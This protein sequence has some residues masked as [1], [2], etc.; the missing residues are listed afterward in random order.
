MVDSAAVVREKCSKRLAQNVIKNATCRL[1]PAETARSTAKSVSPNAKTVDGNPKKKIRW[2]GVLFL[3]S[4]ALVGFVGVPWYYFSK[5]FTHLEW[6]LFFIYTAGTLMA[7]TA[8]YHRLYAHAAYKA[9]PI[10]QGLV[11]FFGAATFEQS[12]LR[13]ASLHRTHHRYTDTPRDPY[14]IKRGFFYAHMGWIIFEKP[15][16]EY[17]NSLDLQK[18]SLV[19]NQHRYYR[20]WAFGAG[21]VLPLVIGFLSG[22]LI[23]VL[24]L[25]VGARMAI[26]HHCTFF[27]NSFAHTFGTTE[28]D[29]D[30]SA[31]DNWLGAILT[32]GEGY[33]NFHH[34]FPS[35]YRNGVRW[36]HW[37]PTKW[38][39]W[40]CS[41]VGLTT[42]LHRT[43]TD[44]IAQAKA[45]ALIPPL[46]SPLE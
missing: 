38:L 17:E 37:D 36:Y 24:L 2:A 9:H 7:I 41:G 3:L 35:D 10:F 42:A 19:M 33:H 8:G 27:I 22:H 20:L 13:W 14:N 32:N 28:Y 23:G 39:V 5:G 21:L 4:T 18:N 31:K 16:M 11:L 26:V 6:S 46:E 34:R 25:A 1:S 15:V 30:S 44:K 40:L 29:P 12:A 43:P 45:F